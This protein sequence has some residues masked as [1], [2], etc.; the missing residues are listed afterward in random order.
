MSRS[1]LFNFENEPIWLIHE[2]HSFFLNLFGRTVSVI[3]DIRTE[4]FRTVPAIRDTRVLLVVLIYCQVLATPNGRLRP[5]AATTV[6]YRVGQ[7]EWPRKG[8]T[9]KL[10]SNVY[11]K[12]E[13]WFKFVV[14]S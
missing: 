5:N 6:D 3:R 2:S 14:E 7:T 4:N 1:G 8:A 9:V 13:G 10:A 11:L 12:K